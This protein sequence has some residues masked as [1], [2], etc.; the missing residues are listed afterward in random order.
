[1][2]GRIPPRIIQTAR[3]RHLPMLAQAAKVT[4]TKLNPGFELLLFDDMGVESFITDRFPQHREVFEGFP[5]RIQKFDF[6]R[7]LAVWELGGFYFDLDVFL[8]SG[9]D[10]LL[11]QSCVFPFEELT[12]NRYLRNDCYIKWP[13][14]RICG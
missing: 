6:F 5:H 7:Y 1:M 10:P 8:V 11:A 12:L 9:L 3:T 13:G 14:W 2:Q 4:L